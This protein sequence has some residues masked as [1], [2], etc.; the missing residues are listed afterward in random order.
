MV[1]LVTQM[2]KND[3]NDLKG[4]LQLRTCNIC[5]KN[6]KIKNTLK[7]KSRISQH[8]NCNLT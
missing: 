7:K 2:T 1:T 4:Q 3:F 6:K 5:E 8:R